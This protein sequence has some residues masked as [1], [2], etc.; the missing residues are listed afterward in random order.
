MNDL[1]RALVITLV[2]L[3]VGA[4][5][6]KGN[7]DVGDG[8][9][10]ASVDNGAPRGLLALR[11]LYEKHGVSVV[12]MREPSASLSQVLEGVDVSAGALV[13]EPPPESS[14][15]LDDEVAQLLHDSDAYSADV[16]VLCDDEAVRTDRLKPLLTALDV[17]CV[18]PD[19]DV[20]G[21]TLAGGAP[22]TAHGLMP[23]WASEL[24][25]AGAGRVTVTAPTLPAWSVG[26]DVVVADSLGKAAR[27]L[28]LGTTT[29]VSND[30]LVEG[31]N[32]AFA[33]SL[34]PAGGTVVID[35]RHHRSRAGSTLA[36]ALTRGAGPITGLLA[37]LLLVPLSLL[38]LA[39]RP[40]DG[41][42]DDDDAPLVLAADRQARAL[43][44][45]LSRLPPA[46]G[47]TR[48]D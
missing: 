21:D 2:V 7:A 1:P 18:H 22:K 48:H 4:L 44:A 13:I 20:E 47:P 15:F 12:V 39:P 36:L 34:V 35:E 11:M 32:A 45:F 19:V 37:L 10:I 17:A 30:G 24:A 6:L 27:R 33:L 46:S 41:P 26:D 42:G 14:T 23:G 29:V 9:P 38:S 5:L 31:D 40:G 8:N 28:V 43:A 16:L 25:V 3:F